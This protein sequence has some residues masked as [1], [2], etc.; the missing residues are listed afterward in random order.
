MMGGIEIIINNHMK[1]ILK[2]GKPL[3]VSVSL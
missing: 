2:K 1:E 3:Q